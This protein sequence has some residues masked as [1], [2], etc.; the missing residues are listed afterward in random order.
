[1]DCGRVSKVLGS[2]LW[3]DKRYGE[4]RVGVVVPVRVT[5]TCMVNDTKNPNPNPQ[6]QHWMMFLLVLQSGPDNARQ[7]TFDS[8]RWKF[9]MLSSPR[10][11]R[12][13]ACATGTSS[14]EYRKTARSSARCPCAISSWMTSAPRRLYCLKSLHVATSSIRWA[15]AFFAPR[16]ITNGSRGCGQGT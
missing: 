9:F 4:P 3:L 14:T 12:K 13:N 15:S 10:V 2:G 6:H 16:I 7:L 1:M 5:V 11:L 8:K